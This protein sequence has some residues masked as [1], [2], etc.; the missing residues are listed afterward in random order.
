[1]RA[2]KSLRARA[3]GA[4][5]R[6]EHSRSELAAK[7]SPHAESIDQVEALLDALEREGLLSNARFAE[8][9]ANRREEHF[10]NRRILLEM[11][12]HGLD[13]ELVAGSRAALEATEL[14][15]CRTVWEKKFGSL[16]SDFREAAR[17]TRFLAARGFDG[18]CI[19]RV[20][21]GDPD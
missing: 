2:P 15:R 14:E 18:D 20:L 10:G 7:L 6:R 19:R 8:S 3:I 4:L 11:E 17:Q 5:S 21:K 16:P 12:Q 13:R 9:L 1:L